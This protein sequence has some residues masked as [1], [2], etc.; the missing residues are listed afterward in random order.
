MNVR[1]RKVSFRTLTSGAGRFAAGHGLRLGFWVSM[2]LRAFVWVGG[3]RWQY[4]VVTSSFV[5][6]GLF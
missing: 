6:F 2:G 5:K 3:E 4:W 1:N